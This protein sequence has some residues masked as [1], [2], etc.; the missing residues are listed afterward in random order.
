[1]GAVKEKM[2]PEKNSTHEKPPDRF[3]SAE[4]CIKGATLAYQFKLWNLASKPMC[5][6]IKDDSGIMPWLNEGDVCDVKYYSTD[7][8]YPPTCLETQIS[9]I[10]KDEQGRFKGHYVVGLEILDGHT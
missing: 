1:M 6:L 9:D 5:L 2:T 4:L 7:S 8:P 3:H 10:T